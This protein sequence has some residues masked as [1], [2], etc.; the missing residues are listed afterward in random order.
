MRQRGFALFDVLL[1]VVLMTV[2][3]GA[4]YTLIKSFR[5]NSATQQMIRHATT[6]TQGFMP[7]LDG[8]ATSSVFN[9][10]QLSQTFLTSISIPATD[11]IC[12]SGYCY[13]DSGMYTAGTTKNKINFAISTDSNY[14]AS[15][16]LIMGVK[17]TGSQVNQILQ[18][19][20]SLF[21]VYCP[22]STVALSSSVT[23]CTLL[24]KDQSS[25]V[26][27]LYLVFPKSGTN[28]PNPQNTNFQPA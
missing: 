2:A 28:A 1:A 12:T 8:G 20:S 21:S 17:A 4:S 11:Q 25:T 22:A 14:V 19:A 10:D 3:A 15:N 18:S 9:G 7:F 23:S 24:G 6:I 13:V 16:Y 26:Y 27:N 5:V